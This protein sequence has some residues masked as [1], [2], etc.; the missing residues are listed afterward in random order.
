MITMMTVVVLLQLKIRK[1]MVFV[2]IITMWIV[3]PVMI[4]SLGYLSTDII[5]G[6]CIPW[7]VYS[8]DAQA[9]AMLASA[10]VVMYFLPM[11]TMVFCYSRIVYALR[12]KV[13][14]P[15]ETLVSGGLMF[16][17]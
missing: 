12:H 10:M 5:D 11:T 1:R 13:I 14:R 7:G 2:A 15:P 3:L 17:P 16:Y 4:I 8:S 9:K 6:T